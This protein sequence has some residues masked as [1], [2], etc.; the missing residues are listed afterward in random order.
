MSDLS[1]ARFV[2]LKPSAIAPPA[3]AL[4][5]VNSLRDAVWLVDAQTLEIAVVNAAAA[6]MLGV[7]PDELLGV[8]MTALACTPEDVCFWDA[9][10]Q[11]HTIGSNEQV[12]SDTWLRRAHR[13]EDGHGQETIPVTRQISLLQCDGASP[14]YLVVVRDRSAH[15]LIEDE[16]ELRIAELAATLESTADGILVLDLHGRIRNFNQKFSQLWNVPG[17]LLSRR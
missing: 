6:D 13:G 2:T 10:I 3:M 7:S 9:A 4:A 8:R 14:Y 16:L 11:G 1:E 5:I 12:V 17:E 15:M